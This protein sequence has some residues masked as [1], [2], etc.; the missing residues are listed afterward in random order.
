MN[1]RFIFTIIPYLEQP[2]ARSF[3]LFLC[4]VTT[5]SLNF[6]NPRIVTNTSQQ[7]ACRRGS[8]PG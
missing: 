8:F 3:A 4:F 1:D 7:R 2:R 6:S 5:F